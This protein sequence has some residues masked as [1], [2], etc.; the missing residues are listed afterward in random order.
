MSDTTKIKNE[1]QQVS[2]NTV[3]TPFIHCFL[4]AT[5]AVAWGNEVEST[6]H[7]DSR[8]LLNPGFPSLL[9][10]VDLQ[11]LTWEKQWR[12][13]PVHSTRT[14][15]HTSTL[16]DNLRPGNSVMS[17]LGSH[18]RPH[19]HL[20]W[21][22]AWCK[23]GGGVNRLNKAR[24]K[25]IRKQGVLVSFGS[26]YT[27]PTGTPDIHSTHPVALN[28]LA[29]RIAN[30]WLASVRRQR[31]DCNGLQAFSLQFS[32]LHFCLTVILCQLTCPIQQFLSLLRCIYECM[33][34][35]LAVD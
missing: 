7:N 9:Q 5:Q 2:L 35:G 21:V 15:S 8:S 17:S 33:S 23:G 22:E 13:R 30:Y 20:I 4:A 28:V 34:G 3:P 6:C 29:L 18:L 25:W 10:R 32:E 24:V 16:A 14:H 31:S 27:C 26:F 12:P 1:H 11:R 19:L